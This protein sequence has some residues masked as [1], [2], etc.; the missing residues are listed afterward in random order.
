MA[1]RIR[2]ALPAYLHTVTSRRNK[3]PFCL[4]H[5]LEVPITQNGGRERERERERE[6]ERERE[7]ECAHV[8][9]FICACCMLSHFSAVWLFATL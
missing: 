6:K 8:R 5:L 3:L 4:N 2:D 7:R 9:A 1:S